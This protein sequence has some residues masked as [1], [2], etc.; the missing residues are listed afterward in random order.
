MSVDYAGE[1]LEKAEEDYWAAVSL[2][3]QT[4]HPVPNAVCFHC[5]QC[6]EKYLKAFLASRDVDIPKIHSLVTLGDMCSALD[7]QFGLIT[8]QL[9][10]L[11]V[12][13]VEF[14]YPGE[15]ATQEEA[16]EAVEAMKQVREFVQARLG[17]R[18]H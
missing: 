12:Y 4:E 10:Q 3:R 13:A 17:I 7:A 6:A 18:L 9:E 1:W 15:S 8:P 14:R 5:Q 11:E 16:Y 2:L